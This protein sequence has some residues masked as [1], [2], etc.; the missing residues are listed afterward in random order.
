[1]Q[2]K[3]SASRRLRGTM[4]PGAEEESTTTTFC[5]WAKRAVRHLWGEWA[6]KNRAAT[7]RCPGVPHAILQAAAW[8]AGIRRLRGVPYPQLFGG[9]LERV[10]PLVAKVS[11][12]LCR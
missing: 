9:E 8:Q 4:W 3:Q 11:E 7:N 10:A 2:A 12:Q 5:C 6:C 1:M